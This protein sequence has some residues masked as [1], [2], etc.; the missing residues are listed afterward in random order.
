M[1]RPTLAPR[2]SCRRTSTVGPGGRRPRPAWAVR[3]AFRASGSA[4]AVCLAIVPLPRDAGGWCVRYIAPFPLGPRAS[5]GVSL[6]S[7]RGCPARDGGRA[8]CPGPELSALRGHPE[9]A[10]GEIGRCWSTRIPSLSPEGQRGR[11]DPA[12]ARLSRKGVG[13]A[14]LVGPLERTYDVRMPR[15]N[16]WLPEDLHREANDLRLPLS[17][18]AQRA[19]AAEVERHRK[20]AAL[21]AYLAELDNELGP[22]TSDQITEAEAWVGKLTGPDTAQRRK[23]R[24]A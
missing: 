18:L 12:E 21:D 4:K 23:P 10:G 3:G 2:R 17:E 9:I 5:E 15:V 22:A 1:R 6:Q 20:A 8:L 16:I 7:G 11:I 13:E 14:R 19:I 24:S